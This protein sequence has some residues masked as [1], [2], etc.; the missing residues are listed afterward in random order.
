MPLANVQLITPTG[1]FPTQ[2]GEMF[3]FDYTLSDGTYGSANHKAPNSPFQIGQQ[4]EYTITGD[5]QGKPKL[6]IA[7]PGQGGQQGYAQP[8]QHAPQ[9]RQQAP[10]YTQPAPRA[11]APAGGQGT[12]I[13][14]PIH[15]ATVGMAINQAIAILKESQ[16]ANLLSYMQTSEGSAHLHQLASDLIR[17][18]LMLEKGKLADPVRVREN[19]QPQQQAP[20]PQPPP[21]P[22]QAP[23]PQR[24]A[25]P[26]AMP[27]GNPTGQAFPT[28]AD[29]GEDVPFN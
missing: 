17:V 14:Q 20:A 24:N 1:S 15:G 9:Q 29:D 3:S 26:A 21:P 27:A 7:R 10:A 13:P 2:H 23:P 16:G 5:Y 19:P 11:A 6:K 4:V 25:A 8:Q 18:A 28:D 12:P 22:R